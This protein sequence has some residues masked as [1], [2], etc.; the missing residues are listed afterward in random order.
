M[1]IQRM[2]HVGVNVDDL[3][4]VTAFFT[5]LGLEASEPWITEGEWVDRIVGLEGVRSESVML[6][7]PGGG[8]ML[9]LSHYLAPVDT[10]PTAPTPSNRHGL[11]HLAFP[12]DDLDAALAVVREHGYEPIGD[13]Q[14]YEQQWRL[15]YVRGPEG[16]IVELAEELGG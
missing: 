2:D 9:E 14:Q 10:E 6:S 4:A 13:V 12:V 1:G 5:A 7:I 8:T 3:P 16:L 11:R 15:C